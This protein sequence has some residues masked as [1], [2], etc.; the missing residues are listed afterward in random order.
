MKA[1]WVQRVGPGRMR[2]ERY[3]RHAEGSVWNNARMIQFRTY[4]HSLAWFETLWAQEQ[5]DFV[6]FFAAIERITAD[7]DD[8]YAALAASVG[9]PPP[10]P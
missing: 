7:A 4:N 10:E 6:R 2:P 8:P 9:A 5:G 3:A 1:P